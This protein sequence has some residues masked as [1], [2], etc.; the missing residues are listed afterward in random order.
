M[1]ALKRSSGFVRLFPNRKAGTGGLGVPLP[2]QN[3]HFGPFA[4]V[5]KMTTAGMGLW[6]LIAVLGA[7]W[8]IFTA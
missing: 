5:L 7:A 1:W 8:L 2:F 3:V 4:K 6:L